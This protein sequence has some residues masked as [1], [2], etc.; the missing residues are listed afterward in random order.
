MTLPRRGG[1]S[2][3]EVNMTGFSAELV[4]V[5][6]SKGLTQEALA[7]EAGILRPSLSRYESGKREPCLSDLRR[8]VAALG[9]D[10]VAVLKAEGAAS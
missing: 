1:T 4:R 8:L 10:P 7:K 6:K 2:W 3:R 9:L 5:R